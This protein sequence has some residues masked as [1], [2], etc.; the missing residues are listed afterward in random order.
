M[1]SGSAACR[2]NPLVGVLVHFYPQPTPRAPLR[3]LCLLLAV[4]SVT[5][6]R[7]QQ[8]ATPPTRLTPQDLAK[9]V[10]NP[11]ED[12]VKVPIQAATGFNVEPHHKAGE[13]VNLQPLFRS[14]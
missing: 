8:A 13:A 14:R 11:F 5:L 10:H 1:T 6:A 2:Q 9:S 12:F 4:L 3:V 7:A